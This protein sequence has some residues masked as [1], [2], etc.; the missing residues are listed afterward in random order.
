MKGFVGEGEDLKP[1]SLDNR[2]T[3]KLLKI[4]DIIKI[5]CK[6]VFSKRLG[7]FFFSSGS[8]QVVH[9][10]GLMLELLGKYCLE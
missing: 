5:V 3:L 6:G 10:E 2:E 7:L 4:S 8:L 1:A 9:L